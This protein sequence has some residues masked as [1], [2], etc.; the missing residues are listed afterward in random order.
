[1]LRTPASNRIRIRVG[2]RRRRS[3]RYLH[4][5]G[6]DG[7]MSDA[8]LRTLERSAALGDPAAIAKLERER[9]RAGMSPVGSLE[10]RWLVG[11]IPSRRRPSPPRHLINASP[12]NVRRA[13]LGDPSAT[14][15]CGR[16]VRRGC[17]RWVGIDPNADRYARHDQG[18]RLAHS[19]RS[20]QATLT[21]WLRCP[22]SSAGPAPSRLQRSW[23]LQVALA[24]AYRLPAPEDHRGARFWAGWSP[25]VGKPIDADEP[26]PRRSAYAAVSWY[27]DT[28]CRSVSGQVLPEMEQAMARLGWIA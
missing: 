6:M 25:V 18:A 13:L 3:V 8:R 26:I 9:V 21:N 28:S 11:T 4:Q 10:R 24:E 5:A 16:D 7:A 14:T 12:A 22:W 20:C 15:A 19:C 17:L 23:M 2:D 1:M 27:V